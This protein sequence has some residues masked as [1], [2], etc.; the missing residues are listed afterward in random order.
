VPGASLDDVLSEGAYQ[1]LRHLLYA[2]A[3]ATVTSRPARLAYLVREEAIGVN[4]AAP[5]ER[6][7]I[8]RELFGGLF[9]D[10][11]PFIVSWRW[12]TEQ[13]PDSVLD[14]PLPPG[15]V[16]AGATLREYLFGRRVPGQRAALALPRP[17]ASPDHPLVLV[18]VCADQVVGGVWTTGRPIRGWSSRTTHTRLVIEDDHTRL[19]IGGR[20]I[21][22]D[23]PYEVGHRGRPIRGWSSGTTGDDRR[24]TH[25]RT[26]HTRLVI[27]T[28]RTGGRPVRGW[29]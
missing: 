22:E 4:S 5:V 14:E 6:Y 10:P 9:R 23:D 3:L 18:G 8:A 24:T 29:L 7:R 19:V 20:P 28:T 2:H 25:T 27:G 13:L 21:R 1:T 17:H 16:H 12:F 11:L 15:E 26:T